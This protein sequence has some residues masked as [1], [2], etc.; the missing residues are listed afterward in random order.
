[1]NKK[2]MY[3]LGSFFIAIISGIIFFRIFAMTILTSSVSAQV[4]MDGKYIGNTPY[5][6]VILNSSEHTIELKTS[7]FWTVTYNFTRTTMPTILNVRLLRGISPSSANWSFAG[8]TADW[9]WV[10]EGSTLVNVQNSDNKKNIGNEL[11]AISPD[12]K[13]G[14]FMTLVS[15]PLPPG[16]DEFWL[17]SI[18]HI[19]N[20]VPIFAETTQNQK[21][22]DSHGT[23]W[24][25]GFSPDSKWAW[26]YG[27]H[28]TVIANVNDPQKIE[29]IVEFG[30]RPIWSPN[31]DWL[32]I[33]DEQK[34]IHVYHLLSGA[35]Q[36]VSENIEGQP[37]GLSFDGSLLWTVWL[38]A[39]S[40]VGNY[41]YD[42]LKL[43]DI[44]SEHVLAVFKNAYSATTPLQSPNGNLFALTYR[45]YGQTTDVLNQSYL[46]VVNRDGTPVLELKN[47]K[48]V[49]VLYWLNDKQIAVMTNDPKI[50]H[51][52]NIP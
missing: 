18:N 27:N 19:N 46:L 44:S 14:L 34:K 7:K 6:V 52:I 15:S 48:Y 24:E 32:A 25:V 47:N 17:A 28:R 10:V 3:S 39:S 5:T 21:R 30:T 9:D 23:A 20:R 4:W 45:P 38:D 1:M 35:W 16:D 22:L 29:L 13:L 50:I 31:A 26:F 41:K 11:V 33:G 40:I 43:V 2:I 51:V 42:P 37:I 12:G 8:I 36:E 49:N